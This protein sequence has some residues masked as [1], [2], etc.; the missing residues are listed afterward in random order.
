MPIGELCIRET[1]VV[2]HGTSVREAAKLMRQHHV[3][4]LVVTDQVDGK[5][6]PVGIIT[7]RDLVVEV[8]A[9]GLDSTSLAVEDIM[10]RDLM[11]VRE[12][13]GILETIAKMRAKGVRRL[14]VIDAQGALAGI[15][16][17]DD[18]VELL[19]GELGELAKVISR[20]QKYEAETR[21]DG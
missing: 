8:L 20:E 4:D 16:T 2:S 17:V 12:Q 15:V 5:R 21:R 10:T 11:T 9:P 3:G 19:A 7:D 14:P 18:L 13:E 6:V 1:V